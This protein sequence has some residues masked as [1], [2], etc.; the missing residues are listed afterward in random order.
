[1]FT[2]ILDEIQLLLQT[3]QAQKVQVMSMQYDINN[4]NLY[5]EYAGGIKQ[6]DWAFDQLN[7]SYFNIE[8]I[9]EDIQRNTIDGNY[10]AKLSIVEDENMVLR[11][12]IDLLEEDNEKITKMKKIRQNVN[13]NEEAKNIL[14]NVEIENNLEL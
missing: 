2:P 6:L 13:T 8:K 4:P 10:M 12:K 3:V 11:D 1:M 14:E 5:N 9:I 7:L